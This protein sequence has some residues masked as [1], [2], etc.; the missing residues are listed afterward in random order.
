M[1][2]DDEIIFERKNWI[3]RLNWWWKMENNYQTMD[4]VIIVS[5]GTMKGWWMKRTRQRLVYERDEKSWDKERERGGR[6]G[7]RREREKWRK[8]DALFLAN[9]S[10]APCWKFA[11]SGQIWLNYRRANTGKRA[12][13]LNLPYDPLDDILRANRGKKERK[14][15]R[16]L[17]RREFRKP[18]SWNR[19]TRRIIR[20]IVANRAASF[21]R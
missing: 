17:D 21:V 8:T 19:R 10:S 11:L 18:R 9:N 13:R 5:R 12:A 14:S 6:R 4:R 3:E 15:G 7:G 20:R 2:R 1:Y 16:L